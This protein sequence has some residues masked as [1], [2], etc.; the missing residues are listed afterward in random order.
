[1]RMNRQRRHRGSS[2]IEVLVALAL[3]ALGVM[4]LVGMSGAAVRQVRTSE[5]RITATLLAQDLAERLRA[6]RAGWS[7]YNLAPT[8]LATQAPD[9]P[10]PCAQPRACSAAELADLDVRTW[11]RGLFSQLPQGTGAVRV[12]PGAPA[13][14]ELWV[15]WKDP[16]ALSGDQASAWGMALN[17]GDVERACPPGMQALSP[18][19][20][21]VF[22]QIGL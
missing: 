11:Q 2:L 8:A 12:L 6:H 7:F 5:F 10:Q 13:R 18:Q 15:M 19:P 14:V 4:A 9:A 22:F 21:C 3:S 1:M 20:R 16:Q 17:P